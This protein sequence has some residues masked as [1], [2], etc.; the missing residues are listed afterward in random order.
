MRRQWIFVAVPAVALVVAVVWLGGRRLPVAGQSVQTAPP[1]QAQ[2]PAGN[3]PVTPVVG[4]PGPDLSTVDRPDQLTTA[5]LSAGLQRF[6]SEG[7]APPAQRLQVLLN[8]WQLA[9]LVEGQKL[10]TEADLDGDGTADLVTALNVADPHGGIAGTGVVFVASRQA[11]AWQVA[12]S[13]ELAGVLLFDAAD[14]TGDGKPEII[15]ASTEVGAHTAHYSVYVW[16]WQGGQLA[17]LPGELTIASLRFA[18]DGRDLLLRGGLIGSAGAGMAQ[19]ERTDRYR[20]VD[21]AFRLVNRSFTPSTLGYHRLQDGLAAEQFG[22]AADARQAYTEAMDPARTVAPA[23]WLL[24]DQAEAFPDAMRTFARMRLAALLLQQGD[25]AGARQLAAGAAGR[26]ADLARRAG[27]AKDRASACE[28][29]RSYAAANPAFLEA[30]GG[31]FG[32]ANPPWQVDTL[33]GPLEVVP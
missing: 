9:A 18:R 28:A 6:L 4:V 20:W 7:S 3:P 32:Y 26:F 29:A 14:L 11:G 5:E 23:D 33:C 8:R 15:G 22:R 12:A 31:V 17:P 27:N 16:Q 24:P 2:P 25:G 13:E 21:G 1:T 30:L 10:L 19:R